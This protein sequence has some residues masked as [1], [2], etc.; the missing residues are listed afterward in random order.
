MSA[1]ALTGGDLE[2]FL[3]TLATADWR[4][5]HEVSVRAMYRW[6][7]RHGYLP[8]GFTPFATV[9]PTRAPV[10]PLLESDLPSPE[11]VRSI[12]VHATPTLADLLRVQYATG[13]R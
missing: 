2:V 4:H 13:A 10:K 11:E 7:I 6:G 5:K 3:A 8:H 9:E 12:I 1:V